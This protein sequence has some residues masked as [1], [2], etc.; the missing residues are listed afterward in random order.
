MKSGSRRLSIALARF[1]MNEWKALNARI[2]L[3]PSAPPASPLPTALELY[4]HV[5]GGDPDS[6]QKQQNALL[7][8]VAQGRREGMMTNCFAHPTR[9]AVGH[10]TLPPA[11]GDSREG[12]MTNCF[13]HPTRI[14]LN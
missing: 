5:W 9:K 4:R 10:H 6:F 3:F 7:P 1:A 14:D 11:L 2:T 12:M 8:T 13:A